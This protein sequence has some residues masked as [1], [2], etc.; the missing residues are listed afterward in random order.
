MPLQYVIESIETRIPKRRST[1]LMWGVALLVSAALLA[2]PFVFQLDG[3]V[4]AGWQQFLG[5]F[6]P[7]VIHIPIGLLVL[8]PILELAGE[9]RPALREAAGFVLGLA[10][11]GCFAAVALGYLLAF[12]SGDSGA[13]VVRH[14]WGGIALTIAALLCFLARPAWIS[15]R[16]Q[17]VYPVLLTALLL[18]LTWTAHQGGSLTHGRNYL[19]DY[20]PPALKRAFSLGVVQAA[21]STSFYARHIDPIFDAKCVE[22]HGQSKTKGDLRLDSYG[23]LMEGGKDGPVIVPGNAAKSLLLTRVMLP[24]SH[25][26]FMPAEGKPPLSSD[27]I[28]WIKAWIAQG[29]SP[30]AT[31]LAGVEIYEAPVD[32]PLQPVGDFSALMPQ[33]AALANVQGAKLMPVSSKASDGLILETVDVA[34]KFGDAQ[35]AQFQKFA[36]Y[37]VEADLGR[38]AIT[39]ASFSTLGSF[40][41]LRALHLEGTAVTGAGLEKLAP[42]SQLTYLNLSS[43][44]V[45]EAALAPLHSMKNLHHLYLYNTPAQ[46]ATVAETGAPDGS[47]PADRK[48][49]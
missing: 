18:L 29:A 14:M 49:Q 45:T 15:G 31:K 46:P 13:I 47:R 37:I 23:L 27:E 5:R 34:P 41:H 1:R 16:V 2:L 12:G 26:Q 24:A 32:P 36:P 9:R 10:V 43:T 35:L 42:L 21:T 22:C 19:T 4:H 20:L 11:L 8:V 44:R 30:T 48:K 6:H 33:I 7:L 17:R 25:K 40:T 3:K 28:A 39:D 38:T